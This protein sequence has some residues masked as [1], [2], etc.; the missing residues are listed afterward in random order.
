MGLC[1]KSYLS[2]KFDQPEMTHDRAKMNLAGNRIRRLSRN[3]FKPCGLCSYDKHWMHGPKENYEFFSLVRV[4]TEA[5]CIVKGKQHSQGCDMQCTMYPIIGKHIV[6]EFHYYFQ[7]EGNWFSQTGKTLW[8]AFFFEK[9]FP[10]DGRQAKL[11][12][13]SLMKLLMLHF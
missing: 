3:Y 11:D 1:F 13:W 9:T 10:P 2:Y 6:Q 4:L 8:T 5:K 7:P 12:G